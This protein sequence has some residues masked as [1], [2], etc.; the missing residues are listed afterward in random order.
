MVL[1]RWLP[2]CLTVLLVLGAPALAR[3]HGFTI[4]CGLTAPAQALVAGQGGTLDVH[5]YDTFGNGL[6]EAMVTATASLQGQPDQV[7]TF[8]EQPDGHYTA[9]IRFPAAGPWR[10][11]LVMVSLSE[12]F[13]GAATVTVVA[14]GA[15]SAGLA[16]AAL[17]LVEDPPP[18]SL[19]AW[20]ELALG[21]ALLALPLGLA[22]FWRRKPAVGAA[23]AGAA[24]AGAPPQTTSKDL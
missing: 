16:N 22:L 11:M 17:L 23:D 9:D 3:A 5:L 4:Y 21:G 19:P 2:V 12:T 7:W 8:A 1:R 6:P 15:A 14:P 20:F 10:V 13:R 18:G 24:D